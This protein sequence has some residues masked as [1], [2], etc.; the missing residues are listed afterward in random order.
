MNVDF[1]AHS[2]QLQQLPVPD[3]Q[4][5][6]QPQ[7]FTQEQC[8]ALLQI[9]LT[10][11]DWRAE[12]ITLF[13]KTHLQP[14]LIAWHGDSDAPYTY[15]G[16]RLVPAPWSPTLLDIR[17]AVEQACGAVFNS[18]LLNHYRDERDSMGLH[19]DD[20]PELGSSPV[21][22][23]VSLGASRAFTLKHK[24]NRT[25]KPI[26]LNLENGSLLLMRGDTQRN[27]R[28]GVPKSQHPCTAR[29]NLTF[30]M[31]QPAPGNRAA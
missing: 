28:H 14:R 2:E 6:F 25:L 1:F 9:L 8:N 22:A 3:A 24:R 26:R 23:S 19:S 16:L 31:V 18:V 11:I 17:A 15:S 10:D 4:V 5:Y 12:T 13:G 20:E 21:I 30:R 27:W 29:I 7:L